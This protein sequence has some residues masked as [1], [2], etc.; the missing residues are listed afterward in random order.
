MHDYG[1]WGAMKPKFNP[2]SVTLAD[3]QGMPPREF[4]QWNFLELRAIHKTNVETKEAVKKQDARMWAALIGIV[5]TVLMVFG[6]A[7]I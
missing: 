1:F 7:L 5:L 3:I 6:Q 2:S 4:R